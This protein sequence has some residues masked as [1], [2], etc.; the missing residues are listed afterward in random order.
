MD[1]KTARVVKDLPSRILTHQLKARKEI[2]GDL[3]ELVNEGAAENIVKG[4]CKILPN[5]LPRYH[6]AESRALPLN[7]IKACATKHPETTAK[8]VNAAVLEYVEMWRNTGATK[9]L[10]KDCVAALAWSTAAMQPATPDMI[11]D[12]KVLELHKILVSVICSGGNV[13]LQNKM[14]KILSELW[15]QDG[16]TERYAEMIMNSD[17]SL[18]TLVL[19][20]TLVKFMTKHQTEV[21]TVDKV[22]QFLLGILSKTVLT[23][24]TRPREDLL[25][26][27]SPLLSTIQHDEFKSTLLPVMN[28]YLLRSPEIGLMCVS[29]IIDGLAIDMSSYAADL[30]KTF[31]S[32]LKS[33]DD[34]TRNDA[35]KAILS[36]AKSVSTFEGGESMM[37]Q[38]FNVLSGSEGKITLAAHKI[39]LLTSIGDMSVCNVGS[40]G[41]AKLATLTAELMVKFVES[42]AHEG[43]LVTAM[44]M[45]AKWAPKFGSEIPS[46]L[47]EWIPKGLTA[48]SS[49]SAVKCSYLLTLDVGMNSSNSHTAVSLIP[50]LVKIVEAAA[51]S[52]NQITLLQEGGHAA[53]CVA[54]LAS[55]SNEIQAKLEDTI[56]T[57]TDAT[58]QLFTSTKFLNSAPSSVL[59]S[60]ASMAATLV[61]VLSTSLEGAKFSCLMHCIIA[62]LVCPAT[63]VRT[64]T[65]NLVKRLGATLG[66]PSIVS[67]LLKEFGKVLN[68][69]RPLTLDTPP[70]GDVGTG[71]ELAA[72]GQQ[73]IPASWVVSAL[74]GILPIKGT[75]EEIE[76]VCLAVIEAAH[77]PLVVQQHSGLWVRL[78]KSMKVDPNDLIVKHKDE[79]ISLITENVQQ[80]AETVA[81]IVKTIVKLNPDTFL[82]FIITNLTTA[83]KN[84]DLLNKDVSHYQIYLTPEGEL[85]DKSVIESNNAESTVNIKREN[86]AYSYKEQMEEIALRK[87]IEEKKKKEGKLKKPE[88]TSKQ[89][90]ALYNQLEKEKK[91]REEVG[92]VLKITAPAVN[93]F[94]FA[95]HGNPQALAAKITPILPVIYKAIQSPVIAEELKDVLFDMREC[96]FTSEDETLAQ[97]AAAINLQVLKAAVDV[98][99]TWDQQQTKD[100][101]KTMLKMMY[102]A[103]VPPVDDEEEDNSCPLAAPAFAYCFPVIKAVILQHLDNDE[104]VTEALELISEHTSLRGDDD[105]DDSDM[106][107]PRYLPRCDILELVVDTISQTTGVVQ[108]ASVKALVD[109]AECASAEAGCTSATDEE[110]QCLLSAMQSESDAVRD[111]GL[112]GLLAM[113]PA[114]NQPGSSQDIVKQLTMRVLVAKNDPLPENQELAVKLWQELALEII[115]GL[116]EMILND[117]GHPV[118]KVREAAGDTLAKL[119]ED[120]QDFVGVAL[121]SLLDMYEEKTVMTPPLV[122]SLGRIVDPA[123]DHWEPRV[124]IAIALQKICKFYN[125]FMVSQAIS[126]FVPTGLSDRNEIVC[127]EMLN[128]AME[129]INLH[130]KNSVSDILPTFE[131]FLDKAPKNSSYD[132]LRQSVVILMGSMAQHLDKDNPKVRPIVGKLIKALSTPSQSVQEAVAKCLPPLVPSIK[133]DAPNI[134]NRLMNTLLTTNN[135]GERKG[136]AYGLAGIIKGLGILSLKQLDVMTKLTDALQNKKSAHHREGSLLAL[137]QLCLTLGRLFEP[138]IVHVLPIL[139]VCFGDQ[140]QYVREA[141]DECAKAVMSKLSAHGVKLVLPSLLTALE[142]DSWRTKAGS[143]EL[144]GAMAFC[145]PKQL[146][147]CLPSIVPKLIEVLSDSHE[148]V[149]VAGA[150]ALKQI[151]SVIRNPEIQA[152]VK[153]LLSA[154]QDP[155]RKTQKCLITLLNTRFVHFIDAPSLALIMPVVQRAFQDRSTETRKMAAQIIG[156]MYSL[157]DQKDLAPYLPGIIPG[158]K[159]SLLDP[160]PEV[161]AVS[162]RALR[163]MVRGMGESSFED[164]LPWLMT[165]LTSETSS[166]DRSGAAQ[167]L[168][169]V[170]GGL[171][172]DKM[173]KLMPEII[174]TAERMDIAPHVKDGYIMLFIYFPGVFKDEFTQYIGEVVQ[175]ILRALADESEYVRDTALRAGQRIVHLYAESAIT[176]LLPQLEQGL[177]DDNWRIRYSS[178][179]LL[180]DLLY[181]ISGVSGKMTTETAS[182]DDNFGTEASSEIVEKRLG[183]ERRNRVLAGLYMGRSDVALMV[184][185]AALHVWKIIVSNTPRTLREILPTL[186]NL[187]LTCLAS[188]SYDKRQVAARTLGDL[189]R[190]LGE[191]V[192]PEIIPILEQGLKSEDSDKRQ[193]VCVGLSE[194][195]TSTSRDM[196]LTFVDSLVPTVQKGLCDRDPEV[197]LAAAKTFDSLHGSVGSKALDDIL[198]AMLEQLSDPE[199]HDF[200]LD[201]LRQVM[202]IKSRAVLP[203]MVPQLTASPVNTKALSILASV[204][205]EALNKHLAKILPA[206]L[207][208]LADSYGTSEQ[209]Q[210]LEYCQT[211]VLSV[212]DDIGVSYVLDIL[213][214][215]CR[216]SDAQTR[217]GAVTLLH[218]FCDQTKINY[219]E[220]VPQLIRSLLLIFTDKDETVL[221]PAWNALNS[222]IKTLDADAQRNHVPDIRQALRFAVSELKEGQLLPGFCLPKGISPV[223]PVF[224]ESI[225][226]GTPEQKESAVQGLG[227]IIKVT[228]AEALKP[229]V[230]HITGPLIRILGDRFVYTVKTAVLDTLAILLEKTQ[231]MLKPF[232]PQLQTTFLKALNDTN[233]SVRLKAGIALSH[234]VAIHTRPDP[235]FNELHTGIKNQHEDLTVKDTYLQALRFCVKNCGDKLSPAIRRG[236]TA[237]LTSIISHSE[238]AT[239]MSAAAALALVAKWLPQEEL[240]PVLSD[241]LQSEDSADWE[242]KHGKSTAIFIML[243]ESPDLVVDDESLVLKLYKK[244][245]GYISSDRESIACNGVR[246]ASLILASCFSKGETVP[247]D[248]LSPYLRSMN[249]VSS[250]VKEVL[251]STCSL[252][253]RKHAD[254]INTDLMK[255][256]ISTLVNGTKEKNPSVKSSSEHALVDLLE[257]RRG[258]AKYQNILATLDTGIKESLSDVIS[259]SLTKVATQPDPGLPN[260]DTTILT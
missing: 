169:E 55:V 226:N 230:V 155:A 92:D 80:T 173:H 21:N 220:Y 1:E 146:S 97:C 153:T 49:T 211:V 135:Y 95:V 159:S 145:A 237:S 96:V 94:R 89:K 236:V 65:I 137:T 109:C 180:G 179:Q 20:S 32:S 13:K 215:S 175:P 102:D 126:F 259:K 214:E 187:L 132:N 185:Q 116:M 73:S 210:E 51:K 162:A 141:S 150:Q 227:E 203:Y 139:L 75:D 192:L 82:P 27:L 2:F 78:V 87:E 130:G 119:L 167:G 193:G 158:L 16:I 222:V 244:V 134:V 253:A 176:L 99:Y 252:L 76:G 40:A 140:S 3:I 15:K 9:S 85:F 233:R 115:P 98:G 260:I 68:T 224:R 43:T 86:K 198:P 257:M 238:D 124:G 231:A 67:L 133:D 250:D 160:V 18:H 234:L 195:L 147:S 74:T 66:G 128:A 129:T 34:G 247:V 38:L 63:Q 209:T 114:L 249:H 194:I 35:N 23:S 151:G 29:C 69:D 168:A 120:D 243:Q 101:L 39:S 123:I 161:R 59:G 33:K 239:R 12:P 225:L 206:L 17:S 44:D 93:L 223:L 24:K 170:V 57:I 46:K 136:A 219:S 111:G 6:D 171:G 229:S 88:L 83:L 189:V 22:K 181:K 164:L 117:V 148:N 100:A 212:T 178:V 71:G 163:A 182:E 50:C 61:S 202:A 58:K 143:I 25:R 235:L 201:G 258:P 47:I 36:L 52:P 154:L 110:V 56:A 127:K 108:Q 218:G 183:S 84:K 8:T 121:T 90:E 28:K 14:E 112:R 165:T 60:V 152:I 77:H 53:A 125:D 81:E 245:I 48:K 42:E 248:I 217:R 177:F 255:Q 205:G 104:V 251:A 191:R 62:A 4:V 105:E 174:A 41:A 232:L 184:R 103:C 122:D 31:A 216:S 241:I 5:I 156:N 199:L 26:Q 10:A 166:V 172:V 113:V 118:G 30:G 72:S 221:A 256:F 91:I 157:T 7:L 207:T 190:K 45:L 246:A 208:S 200:T 11:K 64:N 144:L 106:F 242:V 37:K 188:S 196:I 228:S 107:H 131:K 213:L 204:A 197:R 79:I 70:R 240:T 149:Q 54:K 254:K 186:F 138:Y 142:E 19:G